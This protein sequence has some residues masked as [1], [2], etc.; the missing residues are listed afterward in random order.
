[1]EAPFLI[2][3]SELPAALAAGARLIDARKAG[4][5]AR[6]HIP[7]SA[8]FSTYDEFVP[9]TTLDGMAA[10][11]AEMA[12]RY[13]TAGATPDRPVVLYEDDTGM[14][15]ARELWILEYMGHRNVR[16]LH[17]GL[18]Q[19]V[20]EG[21]SVVADTDVATVR[22]KKF[23]VSVASGGLANADEIHRRAGSKNF[24]VIDVR[25]DMEWAG[26]DNTECCKRRG[27][28]PNAVHIEWTQFL[29]N[30][31][32]KSPAAILELLALHGVDHNAELVPYCHRG[33][34]SANTYYALRYAGCPNVRNFIGSWHEWSA[35]NELP[36]E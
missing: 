14:R 22:M 13:S 35:R 26:K 23:P 4:A 3:P 7:G 20:A 11:A 24:A 34:R 28:I 9:N 31:R 17:G 6:G 27:H 33:A 21:G 30:G 5:F 36:I 1:M 32:F 2:E 15:A 25:D 16:M 18:A 12:F 19:W 8:P 29:E 10:F